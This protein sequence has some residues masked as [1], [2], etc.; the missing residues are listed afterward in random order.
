[1]QQRSNHDAIALYLRELCA[2]TS[3]RLR[4]ILF[5]SDCHAMAQRLAHIRIRNRMAHL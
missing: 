4:F 5:I 1:M 3:F 2:A